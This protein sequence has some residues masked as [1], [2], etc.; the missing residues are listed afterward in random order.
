MTSIERRTSRILLPVLALL[1]GCAFAVSSSPALAEAPA[2]LSRKAYDYLTQLNIL[3]PMDPDQGLD[4]LRVEVMQLGPGPG[5]ELAV[6]HGFF[7]GTGGCTTWVIHS[8]PQ[9]MRLLLDTFGYLFVLDSSSQ[10]YKDLKTMVRGGAAEYGTTHHVMRGGRYEGVSS[11]SFTYAEGQYFYNSNGDGRE[12]A[13]DAIYSGTM[14]GKY[15]VVMGLLFD[16]ETVSG[17]YVYTKHNKP[18]RLSGTRRGETLS[19]RESVD[20]VFNGVFEGIMAHGTFAGTW[21]DA[22]GQKTL[23]FKVLLH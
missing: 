4:D 1:L 16:G 22:S 12:D 6:T 9:G 20:G 21:T 19:L 8:G 10:G 13:F 11:V 23:P 14:A 2:E 15:P 5:L 7:C 18:I 17:E 3:D